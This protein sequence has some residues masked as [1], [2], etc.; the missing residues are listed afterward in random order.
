MNKEGR[1]ISEVVGRRDETEV[2]GRRVGKARVPQAE[3]RFILIREASND[4]PSSL[5]RCYSQARESARARHYVFNFVREIAL[6]FRTLFFR[7]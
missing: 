6:F 1:V 4:T 7:V 2:V 3:L 5:C